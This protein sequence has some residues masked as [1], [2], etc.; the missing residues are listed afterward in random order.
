MAE[1]SALRVAINGSGP[2]GMY[3]AAQ[4]LGKAI[5]T[6]HDGKMMHLT[7]RRNEV[8]VLE[9]LTTPW[10]LVQGSVAPDHPEKKQVSRV[11]ERIA[12]F[13]SGTF[14]LFVVNQVN[15]P[16]YARLALTRWSAN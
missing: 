7:Q 13:D 14:H 2:A 16:R 12:G 15:C 4:L 8:D 5:G 3:A 10:G 1:P 6:W 9:R 11:F